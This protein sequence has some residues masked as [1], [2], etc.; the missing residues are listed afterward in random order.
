MDTAVAA[1]ALVM[2]TAPATAGD[3]LIV[4]IEANAL[5]KAHG[6]EQVADYFENRPA[7]EDP[8]YALIS[9]D[10]RKLQIVVWCTIG[11]AKPDDDRSYKLLFQIDDPA[12]PLAKCPGEILGLTQIGGLRFIDVSDDASAYYF[13]DTGK[14]IPLTGKL[15]TKGVASFY[16]GVG[17]NYVC[18][19]GRWA[20]RAFD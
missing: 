11:R 4:P 15:V 12:H 7:A 20:F 5:A 10:Y 8:P 9:G 18:V 19:G 6:C 2:V 14:R 1:L 3:N 17:E 16:D 13:V